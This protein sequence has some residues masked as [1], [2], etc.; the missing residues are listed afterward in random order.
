MFQVFK[1]KQDKSRI[2]SDRLGVADKSLL[3]AFSYHGKRSSRSAV[4]R[5]KRFSNTVVEQN[6]DKN[7]YSKSLRWTI[8]VVLGIVLLFV[9]IGLY[10]SANAK[11][12]IVQPSGYNYMPHTQAQYHKVTDQA[13]GSSLYNHFKIT[14]S[15]NDIG[16]IIKQTFPEVSYVAVTVP[17]IGSTPTVYIQ[18]TA[19]AI[20]FDAAGHSYV[21]N[22]NGLVI[23]SASSLSP[24][25]LSTL[26]RVETP[27]ALVIKDKEQL[28]SLRT[29]NF[30]QTVSLGLRAKNIAVAKMELIPGAEELDVY[31]AGQKYFVKFNLHQTDALQQLGAYLATIATLKKENKVP[32]QYIDVRVDGRAY[33]K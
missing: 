33:Y 28:L 21:L 15:S 1:K 32:N 4:S 25:E 30:V 19:P 11:V 18:L 9:L 7:K 12:V 27:I 5:R 6:E 2:V 23:A 31:P 8:L 3:S 20:I 13:I 10:V 22:S 16:T 26:P 17:F 24:K 29:V 14:L